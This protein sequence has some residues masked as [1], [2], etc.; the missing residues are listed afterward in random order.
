MKSL[1]EKVTIAEL[2]PTMAAKDFAH[3][4]GEDPGFRA[5]SYYYKAVEGG[6]EFQEICGGFV[7]PAQ[8]AGFA[9]VIG[10]GRHD[11]ALALTL[12]HP[13]NEN[14]SS[15]TRRLYQVHFLFV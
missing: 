1:I 4:T 8:K 12:L 15:L 13:P 3:I 10:L 11:D 14:R 7:P 2:F 5:R 6:A 9:I